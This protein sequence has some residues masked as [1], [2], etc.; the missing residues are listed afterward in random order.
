MNSTEGIEEVQNEETAAK[1]AQV[2]AVLTQEERIDGI[3]LWLTSML[4]NTRLPP[5]DQASILPE[6]FESVKAV[7]K[8]LETE[9]K[10][11]L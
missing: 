6:L 11:Y 7:K 8:A 10:K 5:P 3:K 9:L 4:Q 2:K 1:Q